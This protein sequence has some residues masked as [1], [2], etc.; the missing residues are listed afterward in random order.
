MGDEQRRREVT[1][2]RR[3][4][5][6]GWAVLAREPIAHG[7]A[8]TA[9]WMGSSSATSTKYVDAPAACRTYRAEGDAEARSR[10]GPGRL[11]GLSLGKGG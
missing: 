1:G 4:S 7:A 9:V 11:E 3:Y 8:S 10:G 6:E 5:S 2:G